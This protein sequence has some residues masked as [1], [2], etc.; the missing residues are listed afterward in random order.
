MALREKRLVNN[1]IAVK[2]LKDFVAI[3]SVGITHHK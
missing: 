3:F 2:V 1:S